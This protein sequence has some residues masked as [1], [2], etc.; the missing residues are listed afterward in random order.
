MAKNSRNDLKNALNTEVDAF[1]ESI[2]RR[3]G[4]P[5]AEAENSLSANSMF[6]VKQ[7]PTK[8][9]NVNMTPEFHERLEKLKGKTGYSINSLIILM[10]DK[11]LTSEGL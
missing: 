2:M 1:S 8:R 3:G 6:S 11:C 7:K 4:S 9:I 10:L 5:A